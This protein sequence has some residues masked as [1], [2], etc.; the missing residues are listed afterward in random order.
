MKLGVRTPVELDMRLLNPGLV[1]SNTFSLEWPPRSQKIQEFPEVD[2]AGWFT[3]SQAR[4]KLL[5]GQVGFVD[6]LLEKLLG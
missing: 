5:K 1:K 4:A 6:R 2:R 3:V